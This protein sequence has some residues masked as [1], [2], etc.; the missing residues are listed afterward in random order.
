MKIPILNNNFELK[1]IIS[2]LGGFPFL[3]IFLDINA[4]NIFSYSFLKDLTIF[5][6]LVIFSFIG[7][8]RWSFRRNTSFFETLYGFLPSLICL[9]LIFLNLLNYNKNL[10]LLFIIIFLLFQLIGD[11]LFSIYAPFQKNFFFIVRLPLTS[12]IVINISYL[13]IV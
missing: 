5:Y 10:I 4:F 3:L 7:S 8:M 1:Y 9:I 13:I 2:Y 12:I 6:S 11:Y